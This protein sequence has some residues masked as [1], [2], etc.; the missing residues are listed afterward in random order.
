VRG[1]VQGVGFRPF[2]HRLAGE[3]SLDGLVL[4]DG[5][6]VWIEVEGPAASL[7]RFVA[8]LRA[9]PPRLARVDSVDVS[10]L[11]PEGTKGFRI[12]QSGAADGRIRT[13]V[14]HDSAPCS[15]CLRE[16]FDPTD[17]RY[18]YPFINCT[19]CGPRYTLV[20]ELPYDRS[21]T[22]MSAFVL[23]KECREEYEDPDDRRFHAEPNACPACGP[24]LAFESNGEA[25]VAGDDAVRAAGRAVSDGR[26]VAIKGVGG[27]LLATGA[28][29]A[30]AVQRLRTRKN[31]PHKPF[32]VMARDVDE[33]ERVAHVSGAAREALTSPARP[34][35]VLPLRQASL[36]FEGVAPGLREIGMMLPSTP[37]HFLLLA[38]GPALQVMTSGNR[39]DEPIAVEDE[40]ARARLEGI[41]DAFLIHDRAIH[42]RLDDSVVRVVAGTAQS[43]RRARGYVPAAIPLPF[44]GPPVIA[45]GTDV[46][47]AVCIT[48]GGEAFLSQH[49]GDLGSPE[50]F[51]FFEETIGKLGRLLDV[52]PSVVA[53]DM[54]P[55]YRS[56]G[57]AFSSGLECI[58]VQHH[59]AHI[60]S[61]LT[62]HGRSHPAIG[63]AFDGTG[64]GPEGELWGGEILVCD[65]A[66]FRRAGHLRALALAG[67]EAAIRQPWRAGLAALLDAGAPLSVFDDVEPERREVIRRMITRRISS[68]MATGA[69]RWFDAIA[70][71]VGL[72]REISYEG[73]AAIE[74]EAIASA[75]THEPYEVVLEKCTPFIIDLR[76]AIRG[77]ARDAAA[78]IPAAIIAAR[79]H[80]TL[81]HALLLSV[82]R[83]REETGL[84]PVALSGG[85]FQNKL[86][87][88]RVI[89]LMT[90][91]GF[92]VLVHRQIPP[93][94]GGVALGQAAIAACRRWRLAR[95]G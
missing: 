7:A 93:N 51:G 47:N 44:D 38:D 43:V 3:H 70:A 30:R 57:W 37:L 46:K 90:I 91:D 32:A 24:S 19:A 22:T 11:P 52:V 1:I 33:I 74:L 31:R 80:E 23:C 59:H 72:R 26:I 58:A 89:D 13:L 34:I 42:T 29:D 55:D 48:R 84:T 78:T 35:V 12:L 27:F 94:D 25:V 20:R 18:R 36:V 41:A 50:A 53:H 21:R 60:A 75:G 45:T 63:V 8:S 9:A 79:F 67:G 54:H 68:P 88:E 95:N 62:E 66:G 81:A 28:C 86:L 76:P 15:D 40:G 64:C 16:L 39:S 6:G 92:E 73:Q 56:T 87:A 69:G 83:V 65:L 5:A 17:R 85:C 82:R 77:V 4:N 61:C 2:V 10:V 71:I 14:P 49:I